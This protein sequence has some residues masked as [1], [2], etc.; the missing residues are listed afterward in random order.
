MSQKI[1]WIEIPVA[2]LERA[3]KF[4]GE[5]FQNTLQ[6][7]QVDEQRTVALLP[8][9]AGID[10]A[11]EPSGTLLQTANFEPS[12]Q[13]TIAYFD[14]V[15]NLDAAL[16]RVEAAGGIITFPKFR[17]G[18]GYLATFMDSEGNTVGLLEWDK[19]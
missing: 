8:P 3:V 15:D 7:F 13:G 14:P 10:D 1:N 19:A 17:I 9:G 5:V 11:I 4:Y 18:N 6:T 2:N 16:A 12:T